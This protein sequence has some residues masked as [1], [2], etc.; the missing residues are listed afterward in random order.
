MSFLLKLPI[1]V[2]FGPF[3]LAA[4]AVKSMFSRESIR[5]LRIRSLKKY[6]GFEKRQQERD[7][8]E[9]TTAE[10]FR[11]IGR[12]FT[13]LMPYWD[14]LL[15]AFLCHTVHMPLVGV[16]IFLVGYQLDEGV[17]N[18][19][20]SPTERWHLVLGVA[21]LQLAIWCVA[22]ALRVLQL[23]MEMILEVRVLTGLR[24]YFYDHLM[25]LSMRFFHKRPIGEHVYRNL[26][27]ITPYLSA[28][29]IQFIPMF[30]GFLY[31]VAVNCVL[32]SIYDPWVAIILLIYI[33]PLGATQHYF[34]THLQRFH[35]RRRKEAQ[36]LF[37]IQREAIAGIKTLKSFAE[38]D[39]QTLK[40]AK[41]YIV[42]TRIWFGYIWV[43]WI[44]SRIG[45]LLAEF[46]RRGVWFYVGY[47]TLKGDFTLGQFT[48]ICMLVKLAERP[49]TTFLYLI[50]RQRLY[51]V[52]ARRIL[53]TLDISTDLPEPEDGPELPP[54]K[55]GVKFDNVTFGYDPDNPVVKNISFEIKPGQKIGIVGPS[56]GGKSTIMYLLMRLYDPD[57]GRISI[58]GHGLREITSE[59]YHRQLGVMLQETFLFNATIRENI[60]FFD[61]NVNDEQ[62]KKAGDM[63]EVDRFVYD[64]SEGYDRVIDEES[65][66]SGG[67][68]QRIAIARVLV[69]SPELMLFEDPTSALDAHDE[70]AVIA[71][72]RAALEGKTGVLVT[73]RLNNVADFDVILVVEKGMIVERGTHEELMALE[74][75]YNQ[76]WNAQMKLG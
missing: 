44:G 21:L 41:Q 18:F 3:K 76:M 55:G 29:I 20:I 35:V 58:D 40:Y 24:V 8:M 65:N 43:R 16:A 31:S 7:L 11:T 13:L 54:I 49:L 66:I 19:S 1:L 14:K 75:R 12:F 32:L 33:I 25:R 27:D 50:Q 53:E 63:A 70:E 71:A 45:T 17:L 59:S 74:G 39:Y 73:H 37:A 69:K 64:E 23:V 48:A 30:V 22:H 46:L 57:E 2:I 28:R 56:G 72:I 5:R 68:R 60:T 26:E 62:V 36:K 34:Y 42:F 15:L 52:P 61:R 4:L 38:E 10:E 51:F 9:E 47:R 67:Q 6:A